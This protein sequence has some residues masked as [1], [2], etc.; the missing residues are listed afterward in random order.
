MKNIQF[1]NGNK[2]EIR[3]KYEYEILLA[4]L[5]QTQDNVTELP[6][7]NDKT[8]YPLAE[9]EGNVF[10]HG[11]DVLVTVAGN[12]KF[13]N[14]PFIAV[15]QPIAKGLLGYRILI[16]RKDFNTNSNQSLTDTIKQLKA[17]IP[18]TWVDAELF[19]YN[20]FKVLEQGNL[21]QIFTYLHNGDCDYVSLG[22]NEVSAIYQGIS[23]Q[24]TNLSMEQ[25][26]VLYYPLPLVFYVNPNHPLLAERIQ[27]GLDQL[28]SNGKLDQIFN[29]YF[30]DCLASLQLHKRE[31]IVLSNPN[32]PKTLKQAVNPNLLNILSQ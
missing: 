12:E 1:W 8:D 29:H 31:V 9:D 5:K 6:L 16:T 23:K 15:N 30:G 10:N 4:I 17:G 11:T 25:N 18:Q 19:R 14:K 26:I 13:V 2:S 27:N 3:Q 7:I 32:L 24:F 20:G 28:T 21:Q 22:A